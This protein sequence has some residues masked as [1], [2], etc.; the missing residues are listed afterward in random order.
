V[1][2]GDAGEPEGSHYLPEREVLDVRN[3]QRKHYSC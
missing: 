1:M 2:P 3:P